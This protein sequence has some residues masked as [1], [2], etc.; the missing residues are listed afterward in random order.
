MTGGPWEF[1]A[2][3]IHDLGGERKRGLE[4]HQRL[5]R[6]ADRDLV[7]DRL[8]SDADFAGGQLLYLDV[9]EENDAARFGLRADAR[10]ND[11]PARLDWS[12]RTDDVAATGTRRRRR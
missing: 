1:P 10:S 12:Q 9:T 2:A 3:G 7:R 11:R 8:V 4:D 6:R 5:V